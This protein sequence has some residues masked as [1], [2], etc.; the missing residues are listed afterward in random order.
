MNLI[1]PETKVPLENFCHR[2]FTII[3]L[4]LRSCLGKQQRENNGREN[5]DINAKWPFRVN[6]GQI[7]W[8]QL[9]ADDEL[10]III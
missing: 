1:L 2:Q 5:R 4:F 9:K 3:M 10:H 8:R 7:F 6:P